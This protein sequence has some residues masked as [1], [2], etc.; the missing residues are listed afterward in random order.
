MLLNEA[1]QPMAQLCRGKAF[2]ILKQRHHVNANVHQRPW[3]STRRQKRG[4]RN[5][6]YI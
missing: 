2:Y 5:D 4:A 3:Q 1:M 6:N